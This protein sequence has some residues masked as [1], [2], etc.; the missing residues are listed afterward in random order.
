MDKETDG[1]NQKY[2]NYK[3]GHEVK[4]SGEGAFMLNLLKAVEVLAIEGIY[5]LQTY[6]KLENTSIAVWTPYERA[7]MMHVDEKADI[8]QKVFGTSACLLLFPR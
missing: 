1:E 2:P 3:C 6:N 8:F 5:R 4:R 7:T